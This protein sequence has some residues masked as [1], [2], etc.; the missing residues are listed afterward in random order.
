M[1][2]FKQQQQEQEQQKQMLSEFLSKITLRFILFFNCVYHS[3]EPSPLPLTPCA[4]GTAA[5]LF[6][7]HTACYPAPL[8]HQQPV[9][10]IWDWP[11]LLQPQSPA[12]TGPF[13][14]QKSRKTSWRNVV[15]IPVCQVCCSSR[16]VVVVL[17]WDF[18]VRVLP[19]RPFSQGDPRM[20]REGC[21]K[22]GGRC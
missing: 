17:M 14:V 18:D 13:A 4:W 5:H 6:P 7:H 19:P 3:A 9:M 10:A 8:P 16:C 12:V 22:S 21:N 11:P 15:H 20:S 2:H 1:A